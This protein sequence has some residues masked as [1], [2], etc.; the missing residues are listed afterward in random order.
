MSACRDSAPVRQARE[1][2][3]WSNVNYKNRLSLR[4][5]IASAFFFFPNRTEA[6]TTEVLHGAQVVCVSKNTICEHVYFI[7]M[8]EY[9]EVRTTNIE[10]SYF[11][12]L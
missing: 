5:F 8:I 2:G 9:T 10:Y 3:L 11:E 12:H 1:T 7:Y 4:L 6:A